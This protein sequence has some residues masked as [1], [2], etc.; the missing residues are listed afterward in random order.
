MCDDRRMS[1]YPKREGGCLGGAYGL[2]FL[3]ALIY[4]IQTATSFLDGVWGVFQAF[5]WP[6][7]FVY[8]VMDHIGM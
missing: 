5:F 3:G 1:G 7:F 6:A 8:G 4:H 2:A